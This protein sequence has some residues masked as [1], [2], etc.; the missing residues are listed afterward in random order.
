MKI[1]Y[2]IIFLC[3][4]VLIVLPGCKNDD[5]NG[6]TDDSPPIEEDIDNEDDS[7]NKEESR[8]APSPLS[9]VY[10]DKENLDRRVM[11]VMFDNHPKARWQSG[12][13][14]AEIV[15]EYE[16]ESPYTRYLALYLSNDPSSMGPLRSARPYFVTTALEYDAIYVRVG[17]STEAEAD[18]LEY[19][20]DDLNAIKMGAD[21]FWRKS[22]KKAPNNLYT[23]MKTLREAANEMEIN[24]KRNINIFSFNREDR[25]IDGYLANEINIRYNSTNTTDYLYNESE[26]MYHRKKDGKDHIDE[27]DDSP[28]SAKNIIIREVKKRPLPDGKKLEMDL[29][30]KGTG[31]YITNGKGIDI[32]WIKKSREEKTIYTLENGHELKLNPGTTFVQVVNPKVDIEIK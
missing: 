3:I 5:D 14:D 11:A 26:K 4:L 13:K 8:K 17:G 27:I 10:V 15:Y 30:G 19:N 21:K 16:V 7:D 22:H 2:K 28:I 25:S 20:I 31:K 18:I 29:V 32:K 12:L 6:T 9:G 1:Q 23:D 24:K